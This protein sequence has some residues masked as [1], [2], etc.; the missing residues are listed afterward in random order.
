MSYYVMGIVIE[1]D[2][3]NLPLHPQNPVEAF[4]TVYDTEPPPHG[5]YGCVVYPGGPI[6]TVRVT[7]FTP[8]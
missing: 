7:T 1:I 2:R 4:Q 5:V 8:H 6:I 3:Y